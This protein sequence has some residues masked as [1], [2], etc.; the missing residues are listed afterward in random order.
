MKTFSRILRTFL[1]VAFCLG[2]VLSVWP[3]QIRL[4][5]LPPQPFEVA[6]LKYWA[7]DYLTVTRSFY[8]FKNGEAN[9]DGTLPMKLT[10]EHGLRD[11]EPLWFE[12][13]SDKSDK[14]RDL[15]PGTVIT[16]ID[17][18]TTRGMSERE[19][20][21][22]L[23]DSEEHELQCMLMGYQPFKLCVRVNSRPRWVKLSKATDL[24]NSEKFQETEVAGMLQ[25]WMLNRCVSDKSDAERFEAKI[26]KD[27][28]NGLGEITRF[29][30]SDFDWFGVTTYDFVLTGNDPLA[31]KEI[32]TVF[33]E[34]FA[35]FLTRDT[36]DPDV[37]I[38]MRKDKTESVQSTYVPPT[39][40]VI[41]DGRTTRRVYNWTGTDYRY[42][43]QEH[44]HVERG[45]GYTQTTV[46]TNC[47]LRSACLMPKG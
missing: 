31:D 18:C 13:L 27:R 19:F 15:L 41:N 25:Q 22:M 9:K 43:T 10:S 38:M 34:R 11:N 29:W 8:I 45:G 2:T 3:Q 32:M 40:T 46:L 17:R 37:L 36:E 30:D 16:E 7:P 44:A 4:L 23:I 28:E 47:F 12:I 21:R 42:E 5:P 6:R 1:T 35:P 14:S 20:Y 24:F 26:V 33:A 39:T